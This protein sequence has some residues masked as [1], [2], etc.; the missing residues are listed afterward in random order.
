[1]D[2]WP[3]DHRSQNQPGSTEETGKAKGKGKRREELLAPYPVNEPGAL[4]AANLHWKRKRL[5]WTFLG[6]SGASSE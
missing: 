4:S 3:G 5:S 2:V 6:H 1:M